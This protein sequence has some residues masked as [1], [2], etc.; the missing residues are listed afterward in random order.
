MEVKARCTAAPDTVTVGGGRLSIEDVLRVACVERLHAGL[1]GI[2]MW[3]RFHDGPHLL[4]HWKHSDR[5]LGKVF[6][7]LDTRLT[8]RARPCK[9]AAASRKA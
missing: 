2:K 1:A 5:V 8:H 3:Q 6:S 9:I 7:W 4:L